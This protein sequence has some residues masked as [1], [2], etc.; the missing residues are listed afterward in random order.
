MFQEKNLKL[1]QEII[2]SPVDENCFRTEDESANMYVH[3]KGSTFRRNSFFLKFYIS[4]I[5][6]FCMMFLL[7]ISQFGFPKQVSSNILV[8]TNFMIM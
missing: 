7:S 5:I 2:E 3:S 1:T 6:I 4:V 8:R